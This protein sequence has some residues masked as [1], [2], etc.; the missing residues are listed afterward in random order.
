MNANIRRLG[1]FFLVAFAIII[2]DL[3]YWQVFDAA[4]LQARADNPRLRYAAIHVRRGLIWDRNGT[5]LA[6]RSVDQYGVVHRTYLDPSL[7]QVIGYSSQQ[8]GN[9]EL[10]ASYNDYLTGQK[11]GTSWQAEIDQLEHKPVVG[12]NVTLTIDD[13]LQ[14]EIAN[15]MPDQPSSAMVAD[16]RTG[17]ILGMVSKP[18]FDA[19]Q[20]GN[21]SYWQALLNNPDEPLIN[22][23]VSGFYPPGSTFKVV[24]LSAA[25][26]SGVYS[27]DS[28]FDGQQA[29]G[30]LTVQGHVY[31]ATINNLG[32]CGGR[33]VSPPIS[34]EEALVCSDNIVFAQVGLRLGSSRFIDYAQRFGLG[35]VPSF[36]IPVAESRIGPSGSSLDPVTLASSAFGQGGLHVTPLQ[37]L[38]SVEAIADEGRIPRPV[39]VRSVTAPDGSVVQNEQTGTLGQ[40]ISSG[41]A[42]LVKQA[43]TQVVGVGTGVLAQV[44]GVTMAGKT[45]TAETGD[46]KP[47]HAWFVCFAPINHPRV[48]VVVMVEHGG[49]GA[50]VAAPLAKQIVQAALPL[51]P[52]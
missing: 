8:Y 29:T 12:N 28:Q 21:P 35:S 16:P 37:M 9:S 43:M 47:P 6:G 31:P 41:A 7:S 36:D 22:R 27:L 5:V 45:G 40:P 51:V 46:G 4:G 26:D 3:T 44:P 23:A 24:T 2:V 19:G 1:V 33:V 38:L 32:D 42:D 20:I 18:S 48:A 10:E 30:P 17:E 49:E 13:R 52:Q 25:L 11:V 50:T 34:L 14:K 39:L 15:I